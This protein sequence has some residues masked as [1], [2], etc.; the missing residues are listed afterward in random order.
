MKR[1][2]FLLRSAG[3]ALL[4]AVPL[5]VAAASRG[6]LLDDPQGWIGTR[7]GLGDGSTLELARAERV[8]GDAQSSQWRLQFRTVTGNDPREGTHA[9]ACGFREESLFLQAGREGPVACINRLHGA[10]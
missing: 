6:S 3:A 9:L 5:C 1:R 7:F 8:S 10:S 2:D 4:G